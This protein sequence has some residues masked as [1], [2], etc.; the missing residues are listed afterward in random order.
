MKGNKKMKENNKKYA[1]NLKNNYGNWKKDSLSN[2]GYFIVFKGFKD[3]KKLRDISGN[4]LKL[5][6]YLGIASNSK[7][8]EVWHSNE[9]IAKYFDRS[10]RTIRLWM[11]ELESLNLIK[12]FQ[13]NYNEESHTFLQPYYN[14]D[15]NFETEKYRYKFQLKNLLFRK[16]V[17]LNNYYEE[18]NTFIRKN[19]KNA[20]VKINDDNF[21]I[22]SYSP[23]DKK[24]LRNINK[25]IKNDIPE[26]I[27][28]SKK[29][30]YLKSDGSIV[31]RSQLFEMIKNRR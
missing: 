14:F 24:L 30:N 31:E 9:K 17:N 23:I 25:M 13:L 28:F 11:Q 3:T 10:E 22:T 5:Y 27:K 21:E 20:Y 16:S 29:Y 4:A 7:T 2:T 18:L 12:R 19:F 6:I 1:N 26:L 8:G 15:S